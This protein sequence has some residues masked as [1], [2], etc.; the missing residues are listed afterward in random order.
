MPALL[1]ESIRKGATSLLYIVPSYVDSFTIQDPIC[2]S[3]EEMKCVNEIKVNTLSCLKP[4]SGFTVTSLSKSEQKINLTNLFKFYGVYDN[5][6]KITSH[7]L[8]FKGKYL[9]ISQF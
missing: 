8:N 6:K 2:M 3:M 4:C 9:K 7:P 5:Y 1:H